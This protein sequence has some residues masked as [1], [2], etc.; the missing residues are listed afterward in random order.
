VEVE[1]PL[2]RRRAPEVHLD[3]PRARPVA[4][5]NPGEQAYP[6]GLI[7]QL[8]ARDEVGVSLGAGLA[9]DTCPIHERPTALV[10]FARAPQDTMCGAGR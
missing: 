8:A 6:M 2:E 4:L 10:E 5:N 7:E 9:P 3:L 1:P